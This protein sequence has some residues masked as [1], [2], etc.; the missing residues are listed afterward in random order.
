MNLEFYIARRLI[1]KN[2]YRNGFSRPIVSIAIAGIS[3]GLAVMIVAIAIVTGF[4]KEIAEK[5]IGFGAHFQVVN[6]DSNKSYETL[7]IYQE[8]D[9][10]EIVAKMDGVKSIH[11]YIQKAGIAKSDETLH[12]VVFKGIDSDFKWDFFE[13]YLLE[14][15]TLTI[16][17]SVRTNNVVLSK[18][19]ADAL[20][21]KLGDSFGAYFIQ[22]PPRMRRLTVSGIYDTQLEELDKI[23]IFI[24]I[25]QLRRLNDWQNDQITG[26]EIVIDDFSKLTEYEIILNRLIGN[27]FSK[28]GSML[29][30]R[31]VKDEYPGIF[32]W[33]SLLDMNVWVILI[34]MVTVAGINMISGLLIIILER[35]N[36]IGILKS[37]GARNISIEKIFLYFAGFLI[38]K[39]LLW[40][41]IIGIG[42]CIIQYYT[43]IITL[44]PSSYYV[45]TVPVN[46]NILHILLLNAGTLIITLLM[47]ILPSLIVS[48]ISPAES[49]RFD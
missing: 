2:E 43:G 14:G 26:F 17:D 22:D 31:S 8:Q 27:H 7:P 34:L 19:I 25:K 24:D 48:K 45:S 39:G 32:D 46:I 23:F 49:I 29:K 20:G 41:N 36:M 37:L 5:V 21:L 9:W 6:F 10:V 30:V 47:M 38:S 42:I 4:K 13:Q 3:V 12:G 35:V 1:K 11:K 33:L 44:D 15:E 40:G 18:Y 28:G 16:I